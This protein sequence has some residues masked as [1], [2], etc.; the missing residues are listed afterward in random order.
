MKITVEKFVTHI[1]FRFLSTNFYFIQSIWTSHITCYEVWKTVVIYLRLAITMNS[2]IIGYII[3]ENL[4]KM[5]RWREFNM[6]W[7]I[8]DFNH[9]KEK[10]WTSVI[11]TKE[12]IR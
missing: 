8:V 11:F 6:S 7:L 9:A 12:D 3:V 4:R 5:D 10:W 2:R 1:I